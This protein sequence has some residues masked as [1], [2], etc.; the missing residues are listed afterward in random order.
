M[1]GEGGMP[2]FVGFICPPSPYKVSPRSLVNDEQIPN[3]VSKIQRQ[4]N[5]TDKTNYTAKLKFNLLNVCYCK[6]LDKEVY[7]AFFR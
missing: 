6:K 4:T 3:L 1:Q 5:R 7:K 2:I